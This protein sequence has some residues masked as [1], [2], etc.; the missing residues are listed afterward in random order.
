MNSDDRAGIMFPIF[1]SLSGKRVLIAGGGKVA[2]RRVRLLLDFGAEITVVAPEISPGLKEID[3][4]IRWI[5]EEYTRI[6]GDYTL[7]I[8]ATNDRDVNRRIGFDAKT[9]EIPVSIADMR[10]ESSFWFPAIVR[11]GDLVAG[12]ISKDGYHRSAK[13]AAE[14][15]REVLKNHLEEGR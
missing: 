5:K 11:E 12:I 8:A 9:M 10:E 1:I 14:K 13:S 3:G 4:R 15:V 6:E 7:V 2:E